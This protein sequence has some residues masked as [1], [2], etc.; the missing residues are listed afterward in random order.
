MSEEDLKKRKGTAPQGEG[1]RK[2]TDHS[3]LAGRKQGGLKGVGPKRGGK[4][5]SREK[6]EYEKSYIGLANAQSGG[7][8]RQERAKD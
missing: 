2:N 5:Q 4:H 6:S 7:Q 8:E 3:N 1:R